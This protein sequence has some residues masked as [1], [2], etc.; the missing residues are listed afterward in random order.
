VDVWIETC[1]HFVKHLLGGE[2]AANGNAWE[3]SLGAQD[4]TDT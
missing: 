1:P 2:D 4:F 3:R